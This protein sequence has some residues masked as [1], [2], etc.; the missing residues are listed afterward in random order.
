ME[1]VQ[2]ELQRHLSSLIQLELRDPRLEL[3][4]ALTETRISPDLRILNVYVS[5]DGEEEEQAKFLRALKRATGRLRKLIGESVSLR[6]VP[7]LRFFLDD[8]PEKAARID[9]ILTGLKD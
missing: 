3:P 8:T 7:E 2:R 4:H 9:A 1:K 6:V 5:I